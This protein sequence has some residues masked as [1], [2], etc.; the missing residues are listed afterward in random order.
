MEW[1]FKIFRNTVSGIGQGTLEE[2]FN[3]YKDVLTANGYEL[4][5]SENGIHTIQSLEEL[6]DILNNLNI[7][8]CGSSFRIE[9]W[10]GII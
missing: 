5:I 7:Y 6:C 2:A 9:K 8:G 4:G 1:D 10:K 3:Y